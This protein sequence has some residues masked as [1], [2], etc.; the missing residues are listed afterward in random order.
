MQTERTDFWLQSK[1]EVGWFKRVETY[2]LTYTE[3]YTLTC[4]QVV[5]ICC[6]TQGTQ[7]LIGLFFLMAEK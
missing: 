5:G 7:S 2:T 3:T 4:S 6:M 1:R